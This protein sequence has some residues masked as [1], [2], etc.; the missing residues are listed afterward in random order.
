VACA[1]QAWSAAAAFLLVQACLGLSIKAEE[2]RVEFRHPVL[3]ECVPELLV[4][5]LHVGTAAADLRLVRHGNDVGLH[6]LRREGD[7]EIVMVK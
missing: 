7:I 3:P 4:R 1:P 2:Q 6:V 5:N